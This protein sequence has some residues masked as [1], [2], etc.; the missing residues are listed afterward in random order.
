MRSTVLVMYNLTFTFLSLVFLLLCSIFP[1]CTKAFPVSQDITGR[2]LTGP[3]TFTPSRHPFP[4][5]A[6]D[7]RGILDAH[8]ADAPDANGESLIIGRNNLNFIEG[9]MVTVGGDSR[10]AERGMMVGGREF[11]PS[12]IGVLDCETEGFSSCLSGIELKIRGP[13][14]GTFHFPRLT[15]EGRC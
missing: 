1:G 6:T 12:H 2:R 14:A 5:P 13:L 7:P 9:S 4:F 3:W 11:D 10:F 8:S 15:G